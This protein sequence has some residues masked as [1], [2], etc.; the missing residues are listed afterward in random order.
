MCVVPS[1]TPFAGTGGLVGDTLQQGGTV[2]EELAFA[3][4]ASGLV[5]GLSMT[6]AFAVGLM[7]QGLTPSIWFAI[8][9]GLGVFLGGN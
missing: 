2:A 6:D 4:K 1:I 3:R 5:R 9:F 8:T 7:N